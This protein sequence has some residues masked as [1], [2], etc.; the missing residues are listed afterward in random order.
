[1]EFTPLVQELKQQGLAGRLYE[2]EG[3]SRYRDCLTLCRSGRL[4]L[5]RYCYGEAAGL[6]ARLW[7]EAANGEIV[8][9]PSHF[10]NLPKALTGVEGSALQLDGKKRLWQ[11]AKDLHRVKGE[12]GGLLCFLRGLG[13]S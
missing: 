8:W 11:P 5:E 1:M 7:G 13:K 10:D 12:P 3:H 6:V 9:Q 2:Q 4:L